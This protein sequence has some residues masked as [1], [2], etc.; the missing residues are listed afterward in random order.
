FDRARALRLGAA[1]SRV[2]RLCLTAALPYAAA[3]S[4][5]A[6]LLGVAPPG[7]DAQ[8][9]ALARPGRIEGRV[10]ERGRDQA[11]SGA[12]IVV[13]GTRLGTMSGADG[14]FLIERVPTGERIIEASF[15]GYHAVRDT[16]RVEPGV[17][18]T[19]VFELEPTVV[20]RLD[21]MDIYA[22][23]LIDT[24]RTTSSR[25]LSARDLESML[26]QAPTLD[27][28]VEQQPGVVRERGKLHFRGGRA[29]ESLFVVDGIKVRDLLSGES[30]GNEVAARAAQDVEVMTGGFDARYSQAMSGVVE[31]R[32]KEGSRVWHG[33][34]GYDTD[35]LLDSQNLHQLS[36]ELSGPNVVFAPLLRLLGDDDPEITFYSSLSSELSNGYMPT[37]KDLPGDRELHSSVRDEIFGQSFSY[38][39]FFAPLAEN[40]WR[41]LAKTVWKADANNKLA[42]Y[43]TKTLSI[44]QDWGNPDIGEIDR[45]VSNFPW[46]WA[47]RLDHHYTIT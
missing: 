22:D 24:R 43:G 15:M 19:L 47:Q 23:R 3:L 35:L 42:F 10:N 44:S 36:L 14:R 12:N 16:V 25:T 13:V 26:T 41:A 1:P 38:G 45:N 33:A 46:A 2:T 9:Q 4:L 28:I 20:S 7:A 8:E 18:L 39:D 11:L 37:V 5:L 27:N 6:A 31:T 21:P 30:S 32:I 17:T 34:L 29:D 40:Q